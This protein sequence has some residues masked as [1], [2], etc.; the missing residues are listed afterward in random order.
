M[1]AAVPLL[2]HSGHGHRAAVGFDPRS[3]RRI[4]AMALRYRWRMLLAVTA[5]ALTAATQIVI[6]T[7]IGTAVDQARGLLDAAA[8]SEAAVQAGLVSTA[9]L[10]LG[11]AVLRGVFT[12]TQNYLGESIGHLIAYDL[13]LAYYARL[14]RLSFSYQGDRQPYRADQ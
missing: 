1:N 11:V 9:G 6:P 10:L 3:L 4:T 5:T 8:D 14:Q 7:L 13:R 2:P 12:M